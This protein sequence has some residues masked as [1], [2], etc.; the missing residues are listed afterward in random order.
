MG[1]MPSHFPSSQGG[2]VAGMGAEPSPMT[3]TV[4]RELTEVAPLT[5]LRLLLTSRRLRLRSLLAS[6]VYYNLL[7]RISFQHYRVQSLWL[8]LAWGKRSPLMQRGFSNTLDITVLVN[9]ALLHLLTSARAFFEFC[10]AFSV[11][12]VRL[13]GPVATLRIIET[14]V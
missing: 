5:A 11:A 7:N 13:R 6:W 10:R 14:A 1:A 9:Q 4:F 3:T 8:V 2:K 12:R